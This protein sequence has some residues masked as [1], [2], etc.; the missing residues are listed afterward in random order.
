MLRTTEEQFISDFKKTINSLTVNKTYSSVIF[1]CVGTDRITGDTFGPIVGYKLK[2]LFGE[3]KN[4]DII[5]D[6]ENIV[7][8]LNIENVIDNIC[9]NHS[10]PFIISID[11]AVSCNEENIGKII[12]ERG[13]ICV[14][15][16]LCKNRY[17][18]GD[19][20]I[21]G[22]VAKDLKNPKRNFMLLQNIRLN[23]IMQMAD[24]VSH[25]IYNSIE[26]D[27]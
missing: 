21:K 8:D 6:L 11:S 19:M 10:N 9:L 20:N 25:G 24:I 12:V 13:G 7:C 15:K 5:G 18:V 14:G 22:I 27:C 17:V 16:C 1:L 26:V 4:I 2:R 3:L 23:M